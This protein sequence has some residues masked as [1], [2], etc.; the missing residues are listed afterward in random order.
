[1]SEVSLNVVDG[2][3]IAFKASAACE[4]RTI[5]VYREGH[6]QGNW[7][8]RTAF[9]AELTL[10][11][12]LAEYADFEIKD[13]QEVEEIANCLHTIKVMLAGIKEKA[14]VKEQRVV[15]EGKGN[16]RDDLLLPS[17]YKGDR[18]DMIKPIYLKN[19]KDYLLDRYKAEQSS[20]QETDDVL[21]SYS[22]EG[23]IKKQYIV[24]SSTDKDANSNVGWLLNW[25]KMD[26]PIYI[27]G[28]GSLTRETKGTVRGLGRKWFYHQILFGDR[29]D[30][31]VPYELSG[32]KFGEKKSFDV[33]EKLETDKECW[34][35]I[36][37]QYKIWYPEP[38]EYTAWNGE[39]VK[40]DAIQQMQLYIDCA[41]MRRFEGDRIVAGD[42]LD[43]MEV[44]V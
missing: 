21:A 14:G 22:Y 42:V 8:N 26:K 33:L 29:A 9:K 5:D 2:D 4:T 20:D 36:Y 7:A 16:F 32:K 41:H 6:F 39:V 40:G 3:L 1:M 19:C 25:D 27:S 17:K 10:Q 24:Q 35:A 37:D 43:K 23:F 11:G 38:F 28:L 13:K 30:C 31:Y 12:T 15:I 18:K 44:K 34:Q